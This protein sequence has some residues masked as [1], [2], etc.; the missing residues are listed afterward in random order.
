V[1]NVSGCF[2]IGIVLTI[3]GGRLGW[4]HDVQLFLAVGF[5]GGYTTFSSFAFE[6]LTAVRQG[7]HVTALAYMLG[8]VVAGYAAV[9]AGAAVAGKR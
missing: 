8:S 1:V 3:L 2:L 7:H 5:L 4:R 9:V 6:S